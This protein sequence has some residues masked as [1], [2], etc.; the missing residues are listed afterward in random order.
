MA[1][2]IVLTIIAFCCLPVVSEASRLKL[3]L[4]GKGW[5]YVYLTQDMGEVHLLKEIK[6][7][8]HKAYLKR[9][10]AVLKPKEI[11]GSKVFIESK[12]LKLSDDMSVSINIEKVI[13]TQTYTLGKTKT[14]L[15][16]FPSKRKSTIKNS[17]YWNTVSFIVSGSVDEE[18][19]YDLKDQLEKSNS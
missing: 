16:S 3:D 11:Y 18:F 5:S 14:V 1:I 9:K 8:S 2:K 4:G 7:E 12:C 19:I 10:I 15:V 6:N 17:Y 13:C